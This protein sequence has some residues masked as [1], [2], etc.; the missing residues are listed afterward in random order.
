MGLGCKRKGIRGSSGNDE[1]TT[2]RQWGCRFG[3]NNGE[4]GSNP[5]FFCPVNIT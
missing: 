1:R 5:S 3:G 2:G 4:L